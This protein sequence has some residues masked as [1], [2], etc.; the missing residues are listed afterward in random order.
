MVVSHDDAFGIITN[1][2]NA[3]RQWGMVNVRFS[4]QVKSGDLPFEKKL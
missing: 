3:H 4:F 2:G 1:V